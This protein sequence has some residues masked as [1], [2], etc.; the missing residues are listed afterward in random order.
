MWL[1]R[2][3]WHLGTELQYL[4]SWKAAQPNNLGFTVSKHTLFQKDTVLGTHTLSLPLTLNWIKRQS[5]GNVVVSFFLVV[6]S[7]DAIWL[8][9]DPSTLARICGVAIHWE[10]RSI[11][12]KL[13]EQ[14]T[15]LS[16]IPNVWTT[17]KTMSKQ[18][19]RCLFARAP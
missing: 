13:L 3:Q 17:K 16:L 6:F 11:W 10:S 5:S 14:K 2:N 7:W 4:T 15:L 8:S 9:K 18:L 1:F 19:G 12:L